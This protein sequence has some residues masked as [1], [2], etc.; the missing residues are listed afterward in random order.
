MTQSKEGEVIEAM[1]CDHGVTFDIVEYCR[2]P[3]EKRTVT[4]LRKRWPRGYFTEEKPCP[5]CGF[6]NGIVY[7]S[8]EHYIAG[9]W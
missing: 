6:S 8:Y 7:A 2:L 3:F 1:G 5:R 9:D 4:E